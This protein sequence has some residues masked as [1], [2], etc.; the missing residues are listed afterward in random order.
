MELRDYQKNAVEIIWND[1]NSE[2]EVLLEAATGSGKTLIFAEL[3]RR[4]M[5]S[6]PKMRVI[7]M[8]HRQELVTQAFHKLA[9]TWPDGIEH[10]GLACG[11]TGPVDVEKEVVIGSVQTLCRRKLDGDFRLLIV[12]ECH[13]IPGLEAG[14]QYHKVIQKLRGINPKLK[15]LGVTATPFRLGHGYIYG[16][17]TLRGKQ[18]L[19]PRLNHKISMDELIQEGFLVPVRAKEAF[20]MEKALSRVPVKNGDYDIA[21]L[22]TLCGRE[23][24]LKAALDAYVN[25]GE[26]RK[27]ALIFAVSIEHANKLK[28]V[29]LA[30][31]FKAGAVSSDNTDEERLK[32]LGEFNN[33]ELNVLVNVG[34]LTEGW[35]S[36][37]VDL[38]L[39]CRPTKA[40]S[41]FVQM[42][43]RGARPFEGKKDLLI[44]DLA[45]N[46]KTHGSP[47]SPMVSLGSKKRFK[48]DSLDYKICPQ[49]MEFVI[50]NKAACPVCGFEFRK[51]LYEDEVYAQ[52]TMR[53]LGNLPETAES[54]IA[55]GEGQESSLEASLEPSLEASLAE[56]PKEVSKETPKETLRE[57]PRETQKKVSE[58]SYDDFYDD[59]EDDA[60]ERNIVRSFTILRTQTRKGAFMAVLLVNCHPGGC[61]KMWLDVEGNSSEMG[62]YYAQIFWSKL[63]GGKTPPKTIKEAVE[64]AGELKIPKEITVVMKNGFQQIK[65]FRLY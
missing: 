19:F 22:S 16:T 39:M 25:K 34:I 42:V 55:M 4:F 44:L 54:P 51:R 65:E 60:E 47:S 48:R 31:G 24:C 35:D 29:F 61:V 20:P 11:G 57:T 58:D 53:L 13:H 2:N 3:I 40:P 49:C 45:E 26:G 59:F 7:V 12:D 17:E 1:L 46:F 32:V 10:I 14:G 28:D 64:R 9:R 63:S 5:T 30:E 37:K 15:I 8:A 21:E 27:K 52:P 50:M 33:G 38:I 6:R 62:R 23:K 43:G 41:L 18:N 36:P 56:P